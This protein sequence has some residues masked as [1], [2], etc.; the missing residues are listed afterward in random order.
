MKKNKYAHSRIV[1]QGESGLSLIEVMI[2]AA[3]LMFIALSVGTI[4]QFTSKQQKVSKKQAEKFNR[5]TAFSAA[6]KS[7]ALPIKPVEP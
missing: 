4:V 2:A 7:Q 1:L 6:L 3:M 5:M